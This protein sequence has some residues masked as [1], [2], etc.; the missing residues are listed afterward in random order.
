MI[1][2]KNLTKKFGKFT[3]LQNLN[4]K[5]EKGSSIALIGPNGCGK[6]TLIKCILG[7][8]FADGDI[9]VD[10][11]NVKDHFTYRKN[12]GYM[13]QIGH[14]PEDMTIAQTINMLTELRNIPQKDLDTELHGI[15]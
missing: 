8:N 14:Y 3:A 5:F 4:A 6:T 1:E 15:L 9:L 11:E 7:L 10:T 2:V 13:P 12:I